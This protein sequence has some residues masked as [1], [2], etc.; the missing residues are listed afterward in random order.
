MEA[1]RREAAL[2]RDAGAGRGVCEVPPPVVPALTSRTA[3][4][5]RAAG[6]SSCPGRAAGGQEKE[7]SRSSRFALPPA[8]ASRS[9]GMVVLLGR[10]LPSLLALFKKKGEPDASAALRSR[11][12]RPTAPSPAAASAEQPGEGSGRVQSLPGGG[13]LRVRGWGAAGRGRGCAAPR[14]GSLGSSLPSSPAAPLLPGGLPGAEASGGGRGAGGERRAALGHGFPPPRLFQPR[15]CLSATD[16]PSPLAG[17]QDGPGLF[18]AW[19]GGRARFA[20]ARSLLGRGGRRRPGRPALLLRSRAPSEPRKRAR[21]RRRV[22]ALELRGE[23]ALEVGADLWRAAW[24]EKLRRAWGCP[25]SPSLDDGGELAAVRR[26][27][28]FGPFGSSSARDAAAQ[29]ASWEA[30]GVAPEREKL[31]GQGLSTFVTERCVDFNSQGS[32]AIFATWGTLGDEVHTPLS[33]CDWRWRIDRCKISFRLIWI[34]SDFVD[35]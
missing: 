13:G 30:P 11:I 34:P 27:G 5:P 12:P 33:C 17:G 9:G 15:L 32:L 2:G 35:T 23:A 16:R 7:A 1:S 4:L 24:R 20:P 3:T 6:P 25:A 28:A 22:G 14:L 29:P 10:N 18:R 26:L 31:A 21:G 19:G 8:G